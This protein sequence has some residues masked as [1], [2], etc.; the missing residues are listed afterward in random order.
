MNPINS[1]LAATDFSAAADCAV[2]RAARLAQALHAPLHLMHVVNAAQLSDFHGLLGDGH[3][4]RSHVVTEAR[5]LMDA[6]AARLQ[7]KPAYEV[8]VGLLPGAIHDAALAHGLLVLGAQGEGGIAQA[9]LGST[10]E[11]LILKA[12]RPTLVVK[13]EYESEYRRVIVPCEYAPPARRALE[14]ALQVAPNA[15][16]TLVHAFEVEFESAIWRTALGGERVAAVRSDAESRTREWLLQIGRGLEGAANVEVLAAHGKPRRVIADLVRSEG[17]DLMVMGK[18][19]RSLAGHYF[20]GSV[21]RA[22]LAEAP[23]DV[24]IAP[25]PASP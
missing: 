21:T 10:A 12:E 11:R 23:C 4:A 2:R 20:M 24:L 3:D 14:Y 16:I 1:I 6:A 25:T 18:Q 13:R 9:L 7:P 22:A 19:G 5:R 15:R 8:L 17:A